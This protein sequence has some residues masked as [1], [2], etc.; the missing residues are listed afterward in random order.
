MGQENWRDLKQMKLKYV[1]QVYAEKFMPIF[2]SICPWCQHNFKTGQW[3]IYLHFKHNWSGNMTS[4]ME[5][6]KLVVYKPVR[7]LF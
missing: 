5:L 1:D 2:Y 4:Q 3:M 7:S 6:D